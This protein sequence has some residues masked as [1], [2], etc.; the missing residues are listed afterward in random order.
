MEEDGVITN[1]TIKTLT[2][3]EILDFNFDHS[4]VLNKVILRSESLKEV[5]NDLDMSSDIV[6][7][8]LSPDAPYFR[9]V[10]VGDAGETQADIPKDCDIIDSFQ[11][12]SPIRSRYMVQLFC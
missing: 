7:I 9:F 6:E 10:T 8:F 5:M 11:C 12:S 2:A 1:C 4:N 3:E